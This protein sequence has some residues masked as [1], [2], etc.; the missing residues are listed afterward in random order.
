MCWRQLQDLVFTN[1]LLLN[2]RCYR[3]VEH[4]RRWRY[5]LF[6]YVSCVFQKCCLWWQTM[7][8]WTRFPS[9]KFV[10][11]TIG[12]ND[13]NEMQVE[14]VIYI[15]C[16]RL[17]LMCEILMNLPDFQKVQNQTWYRWILVRIEKWLYN[18]TENIRITKMYIV[19]T[20]AGET[21]V[22][23]FLRY[24]GQVL[25]SYSKFLDFS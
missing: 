8:N 13:S 2:Q 7:L 18:T 1:C 11:I 20:D 12:E 24:S 25:S 19:I 16:R 21:C 4:I 6:T 5:V 17:T 14:L 9:V 23:Q 3:E 15:R 22:L 10:N